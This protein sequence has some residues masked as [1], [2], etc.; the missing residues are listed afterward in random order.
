MTVMQIFK[1]IRGSNP[2]LF[3]LAALMLSS[4][5]TS[6]DPCEDFFEYACGNWITVNPIPPYLD[7]WEVLEQMEQ[8]LLDTLRGR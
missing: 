2:H 6:V 5:K 3:P 4:M 7:T 1:C 8:Q